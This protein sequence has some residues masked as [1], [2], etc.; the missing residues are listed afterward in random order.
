MSNQLTHY[1]QHK[2]VPIEVQNKVDLFYAYKYNFKFFNEQV[3]MEAIPQTL[4]QKIVMHSA[5]LLIERVT[6]FASLPSTVIAK[7]VSC[8]HREIVLENDI[9]IRSGT[10]GECMFFIS[11]GTVAVFTPSGRE[12][13][14]LQDGSYFGEIALINQRRIRVATIVA[15]EMCELYR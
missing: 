11:S 10:P 2:G 8:L 13:C 5:R 15:V 12:I 9:I 4:R 6:F 1:M 3:I 14:H 7:I